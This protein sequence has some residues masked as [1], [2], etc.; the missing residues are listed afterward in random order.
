MDERGLVMSDV[1]PGVEATI[2]WREVVNNAAPSGE[3]ILRTARVQYDGGRC[4]EIAAH[5]VTVR[6]APVFANSI[7]GLP[8]GLDGMVGPSAGSHPRAI[9]GTDFVELP[10]ATPVSRPA[11]LMPHTMLSL[12]PSNGNG[13][14]HLENGEA[15]GVRLVL[16]FDRDRLSRTLRFLAESRFTGLV[17]HLFAIRAFFPDAAGNSAEGALREVRE[18]LR[19]TLDRLFIKLRLPNY[20]IAPRDLESAA[21]RSAL[22]SL[23]GSVAGDEPAPSLAGSVILHG[24]CEEDELRALR[25]RLAEAPLA[26]ALPWATLARLVTADGEGLQHYR[27]ML[28]ATLDELADADETAFIDALQRR[29]YPVLDAALDVVRAQLGNV[30]A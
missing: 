24:T 7:S 17:S 14:V 4:D 18:S 27:A 5:E 10:P 9:G 3:M 2:R 1:D 11:E 28:I 22:E 12:A 16:A 13:H 19:E 26:T 30:R 21:A 25:D 20:V 29:P 15:H 8:F 6:C 23:L